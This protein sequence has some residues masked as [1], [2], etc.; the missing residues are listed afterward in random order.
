MIGRVLRSRIDQSRPSR[1]F[2]ELGG[3]ADEGMKALEKSYVG[4]PQ[5]INVLIDWLHA[6]GVR[7]IST[8]TIR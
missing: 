7:L 1:R 2:L 8:V 3:D 6:A 5:M 4:L